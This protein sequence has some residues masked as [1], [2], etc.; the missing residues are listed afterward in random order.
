MKSIARITLVGWVTAG[1]LMSLPAL[2]AGQ[3][4][5]EQQA[6]E[7]AKAWLALVDAGSYAESWDAAAPVFQSAVTKR[8]WED[9]LNQV[10]APLGALQSRELATAEHATDLPSAPKGEYV[11]IR[12]QT[13]FEN[14]ESAIET[15]VPM[16]TD[17][18]AWKVSGYFIAPQ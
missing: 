4:D 7:A 2:A 9:S 6:V 14:L 15:V 17:D 12:F 16:R 3:D 13:S 10:R 5:Q 8:G 1:A 18:G 11:V